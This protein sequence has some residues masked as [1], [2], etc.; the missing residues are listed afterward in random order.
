MPKVSVI[1]P[2]YN[3]ENFIE[4]TLKSVLSQTYKDFEVIV[5]D[6]DS[7]DRTGEIVNVIKDKRI[8]YIHQENGGVS[9]ARNNGILNSKGEYIALLDHDDLWL[10]EK[11]ERQMPTLE[12]NSKIGLVYSD[13]HIVDS[14]GRITG[15]SFKDHPPHRGNIIPDLF[16]GFL[17]PD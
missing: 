16:L 6:D 5:V 8:V 17:R 9:M 15:R 14:K 7:K 3:C 10:P 11:L 1:I 13:C 2:V 12:S 4:E